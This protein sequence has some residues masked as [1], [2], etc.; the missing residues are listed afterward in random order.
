MA[1]TT[2]TSVEGRMTLME[3]LAELRRRLIISFAAIA[4]GAVI[5]WILYPQIIDFLLKPYTVGALVTF[6]R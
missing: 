2:E 5:C 3:H 1:A 4:V 6:P